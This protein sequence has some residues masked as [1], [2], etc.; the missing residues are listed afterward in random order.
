[1]RTC[2]L[3]NI[4]LLMAAAVLFGGV[5]SAQDVTVKVDEV[6]DNRVTEGPYVGNL[7]VVLNLEGEDLDRV[8][9]ARVLVKAAKDDKGNDLVPKEAG[10]PD[11]RSRNTNMGQLPV[12]LENPAR[13]ATTVALSGSAE[14]FVPSM[15]PNSTI[16]IEKVTSLRDKAIRSKALDAAEMK[17]SVLSPKSY[18]KGQG[19]KLGPDEIAKIREKGKKEG[20]SDEEINEAIEFVKAMQEMGGEVPDD[21]VILSGSTSDI[22]RI[23]QVRLLNADGSEISIPSRSWSSEGEDK[24]MVVE[25]AESPSADTTLELTVVTKKSVVSVPF[26]LKG[27]ELP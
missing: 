6:N 7:E 1:M 8:D 25:P 13:S 27:I 15:D 21:A 14:L 22:D 3:V 17:L 2:Q 23:V 11:F 9:S 16:S 5:L 18:R 10:A 4:G 12:S 20:A 26:E 24:V 19:K